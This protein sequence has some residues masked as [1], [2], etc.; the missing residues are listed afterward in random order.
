MTDVLSY[1]YKPKPWLM[2]LVMAFFSACAAMLGHRAITN[3]RGL[4]LN[5]I[6]SMGDQGATVFYTILALLS[7]G[8]V[9][10]GALGVW[11]GLRSTRSAQLTQDAVSCP[12]S[13]FSKTIITVPYG[14][15]TALETSEVQKQVFLH[16]HHSGGKLTI[17]RQMFPSNDQFE[18][19]ATQLADRVTSRQTAANS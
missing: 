12:K 10:I 16:V 15:I 6:L 19:F 14:D 8:F 7:I 11:S 5:G 18:T 3:D 13:G 9:V 1:P 2:L 17:A 4:I